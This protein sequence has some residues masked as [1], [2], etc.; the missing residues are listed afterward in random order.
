MPPTPSFSLAPY[1][2]ASVSPWRAAGPPARGPHATRS[3]W[4]PNLIDVRRAGL[5]AGRRLVLDEPVVAERALLGDAGDGF[6]SGALTVAP[7]WCTSRRA[8]LDDAERAPRHA[9]AAAVADVVLHHHGAELGAEQRT[10]RAHVQAAGVGAVLADVRRHQ[11]AELRRVRRCG[12]QRGAASGG[13]RA[14]LRGIDRAGM[15]RPTRARP[16]SRA[17]VDAA[18]GSA[19]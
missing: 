3:S 8:P 5:G 12:V 16:D 9:V 11:P 7:V 14:V 4:S 15:P 13:R 1:S 18:R 10:G 2:R 6:F 17:C 19:R